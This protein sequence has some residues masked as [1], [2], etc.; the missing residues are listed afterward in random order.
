MSMTPAIF[1]GNK[2]K[3]GCSVF[4]LLTI[5]IPSNLKS[6]WKPCEATAG[7][8]KSP[9]KIFLL[10]KL[11][12]VQVSHPRTKSLTKTSK[13]TAPG[14]QNVKAVC[15]KDKLEF[16]VW[17]LNRGKCF[18]VQGFWYFAEK[19][20]RFRGISRGKFAE[21]SADF[22]GFSRGKSQNSWNNRPI[23]RDFSG[24]K[25]IFEGFSVAYS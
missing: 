23:S 18:T 20:A 15:P 2:S 4:H 9:D 21:K 6:K 13:H 1:I 5:H 14:K 11:A 24:K 8:E 16:K 22:A 3:M 7:L 17:A 25:S 10:G 12:R 19:K